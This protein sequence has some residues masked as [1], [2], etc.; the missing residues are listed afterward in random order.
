MQIKDDRRDDAGS[1][2]ERMLEEMS[3]Q[4]DLLG[5]VLAEMKRANCQLEQVARQ[6]CESGGSSA[7]GKSRPRPASRLQVRLRPL[8]RSW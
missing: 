4:T 2:V 7:R 8:L 3:Y 1:T 6:T 5:R